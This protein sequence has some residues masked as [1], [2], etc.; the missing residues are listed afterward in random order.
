MRATSRYPTGRDSDLQPLSHFGKRHK[1]GE[2]KRRLPFAAGKVSGFAQ[3][4]LVEDEAFHRRIVR[5]LLANTGIGLV[6]VEDGQAALDLLSIRRFDLVLLDTDLPRLT[7]PETLAWLRHSYTP[8]SDI[9]VLALVAAGQAFEASKMSA[10]GIEGKV[11]KPLDRAEFY[12][13]LVN[14]LPTL[15]RTA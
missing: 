7:G 1:G 14:I 2:I 9:P 15:R 10:I 3:I 8:W 12:D 6:E 5:L 4:L 13:A 11:G